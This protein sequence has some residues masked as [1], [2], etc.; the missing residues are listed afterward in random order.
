MMLGVG[1]GV[2]EGERGKEGRG[3]AVFSI[4]ISEYFVSHGGKP[5]FFCNVKNIK[6]N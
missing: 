5:D 2:G 6:Q 4:I 3:G 1:V